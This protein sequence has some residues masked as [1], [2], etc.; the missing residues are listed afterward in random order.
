ML[1]EFDTADPTLFRYFDDYYKRQHGS[2]AF[3][4]H[5]GVM[6]RGNGLAGMFK[7]GLSSLIPMIKSGFKSVGKRLLDT[8]VGIAQDALQ[9][10]NI[11]ESAKKRFK[12]AAGRLLDDVSFSLGNGDNAG[13]P[14][15]RKPKQTNK[16]KIKNQTNKKQK[17]KGKP[18]KKRDIF[19]E[20]LG[21]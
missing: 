8:G 16:N 13:V 1:V 11:G 12:G 20:S 21:K 18:H 4:V 3:A 10:E 9:G 15:K 14:S 17:K 7:K 2:G 5:R 19:R 6:Q